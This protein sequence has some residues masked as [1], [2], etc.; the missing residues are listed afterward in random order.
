MK[1][2]SKQTKTTEKNPIPVNPGLGE[3]PQQK[4]SEMA[5]FCNLIPKLTKGY[6]ICKM[7]KKKLVD[8]KTLPG[9]W[10]VAKNE[11]F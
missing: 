3:K 6:D 4:F 8:A 2:V 7:T 1:K 9:C 5:P 11:D 10:L